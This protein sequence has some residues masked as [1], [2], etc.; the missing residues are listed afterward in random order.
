MTLPEELRQFANYNGNNL[1]DLLNRAADAIEGKL[2]VDLIDT[3]HEE[4][5]E[6]IT[7]RVSMDPSGIYIRPKGY[8]DFASADGE[9]CPVMIEHCNGEMRVLMWPDI[10]DEED[11]HMVSLAGA[12]ESHRKADVE[13]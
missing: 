3:R 9:G 8:G 12:K 11:L 2:T 7:C 10:N 4:D 1:G 13:D 6:V 5:G